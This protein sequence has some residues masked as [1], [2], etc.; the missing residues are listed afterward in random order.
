[1]LSYPFSGSFASISSKSEAQYPHTLL[2]WATT[3]ALPPSPPA[4]SSP[5][6]LPCRRQRTRPSKAWLAS[7]AAGRHFAFSCRAS[8]TRQRCKAGTPQRRGSRCS[9]SGSPWRR[10]TTGFEV[11]DRAGECWQR[12]GILLDLASVFSQRR[13]LWVVRAGVLRCG[14]DS[15][16]MVEP[17]LWWQSKC[18]YHITAM[19]CMIAPP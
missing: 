11:A 7:T 3:R 12:I 16:S 9:S 2:P 6:L 5:S 17:V 13:G 1:M 10:R 4:P 18:S 14:G 8:A 19:I 15:V